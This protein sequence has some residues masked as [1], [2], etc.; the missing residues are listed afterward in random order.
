MDAASHMR[1]IVDQQQFLASVNAETKKY[2][3]GEAAAL[4][5]ESLGG[6]FVVLESFVLKSGLSSDAALSSIFSLAKTK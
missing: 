4:V 3:W 6:S 5:G 1:A 2:Q